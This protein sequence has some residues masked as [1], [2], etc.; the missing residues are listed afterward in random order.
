MIFHRN[1]P[2]GLLLASSITAETIAEI[3]N[4]EPLPKCPEVKRIVEVRSRH[5]LAK[6]VN[7]NR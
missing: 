4:G 1:Q 5:N 7:M 2:Y 6:V 3:C